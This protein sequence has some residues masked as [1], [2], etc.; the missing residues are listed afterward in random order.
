MFLKVNCCWGK[1]DIVKKK[2]LYCGLENGP[3]PF[4]CVFSNTISLM[5]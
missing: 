2:I 4:P 1:S 3:L 5:G